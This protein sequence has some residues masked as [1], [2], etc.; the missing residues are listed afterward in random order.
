[1][2]IK[3][4]FA[5]SFSILLFLLISVFG[6][7]TQFLFQQAVEEQANNFAQTLA[8]QTAD[9]VTE[10]VL[11]ND[12]L[13]LK[14]VLGQ[15]IEEPGLLGATITDVDRQVLAS[16]FPPGSEVPTAGRIFA[17]PITLQDSVAGQVIFA[18]DESL[19]DE[20]RARFLYLYAGTLLASL[21]FACGLSWWLCEQITTPLLL[22]LDQAENVELGDENAS[23]TVDREDEVGQLQQ[24]MADLI[25]H[26]HHL[27]E[28]LAVTGMPDPEPSDAH[29]QRPERRMATVL[30]IEVVN[31][32]AAVELLH[33]ATL[34]TLLQQYQFYLRQASRLYRGVVTQIGGDRAVVAFD[35]RQCQ[36]EHAFNAICCGQLFLLL[37]QRLAD[38]QR[39]RNAQQL[40]FRLAVHSGDVFFS[41]MWR[42]PKQEKDSPRRE[43]LIGPTLSLV[44]ELLTHAHTDHILASE[45]SYDLANGNLRF[46]VEPGEGV[47]TDKRTILTYSIPA[48]CGAHKELLEKQCQHLL[49]EQS[50]NQDNV[51]QP[52]LG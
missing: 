28:Q 18:F 20:P 50:R 9:S 52:G 41:P 2:S 45:L 35:V 1:M 3:Q 27:E 33:P 51:S 6:F 30:I 43:T 4:K 14:I 25:R 39:S 7:T 12:L 26:Q 47:Q 5:V 21:I 36:D 49:P 42:S 19:Q 38:L 22:L 32:T 11:A 23:I 48:D 8:K 16:T 31:S 15:L 40:E 44:Q 34:S 13:G 29:L 24:R 37:M 10:L 46:P 17:A